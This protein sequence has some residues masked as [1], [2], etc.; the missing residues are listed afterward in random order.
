MYKLDVN[1]VTSNTLENYNEV[2]VLLYYFTGTLWVL[3]IKN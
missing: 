1:P 2:T 3:K